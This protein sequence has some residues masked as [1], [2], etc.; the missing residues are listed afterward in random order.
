MNQHIVQSYDHELDHLTNSILK[1]GA[2]VKEMLIIQAK[3]VN[4]AGIDYINEAENLDLKINDQDLLIEQDATTL[5]ATRQPL[6]IDLRQITSA[7]KIAVIMERMGDLS[8]N[9]TRRISPYVS[10]IPKDI[11]AD[12]NQTT[13]ILII[14]L[15]KVL[16]SIKDLDLENALSVIEKDAHIDSIYVTLLGK[17][18]AMIVKNKNMTET[19]IQLVIAIKNIERIGDYI[20]KVAKI[21]YYIVTG[22]SIVAKSQT[23]D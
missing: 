13:E 11:I 15:D 1:I 19:M 12:I 5:I 22:S 6:A 16:S 4:N 23:N 10:D 21:L 20:T 18:S 8:K 2:M 3:A 9:I 17:L 14:M 7:I